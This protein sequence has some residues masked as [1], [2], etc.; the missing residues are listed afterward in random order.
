[1]CRHTVM[2]QKITIKTVGQEMGA[3][4]ILTIVLNNCKAVGNKRMN[5]QA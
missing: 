2:L 1:M 4:V 3:W 5:L